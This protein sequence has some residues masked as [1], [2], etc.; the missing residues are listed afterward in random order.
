MS[1]HEASQEPLRLVWRKSSYS[2]EEGGEC[3]EVATAVGSV[4]VRDSK[5]KAGSM[6]SFAAGQWATFVAFAS[7]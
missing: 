7:H 3:V 2:S 1:V 5:N 4:H 6:L